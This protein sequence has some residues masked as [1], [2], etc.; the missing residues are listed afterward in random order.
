MLFRFADHVVDTDRRELSRGGA[1]VHVEPQVFD[2]LVHLIEERERVVGRDELFDV[3]WR[4]RIVSDATLD[5][6]I[7]AARRAVGDTGSRQELIRTVP[8][9]GYRFVGRLEPTEAPAAEGGDTRPAGPGQQHVTFCR[10]GDGTRIA[11]ASVGA[12][13]ALVKTA[14][15]L[16]HLEFDWESPVWAPL[17]Q[18]LSERH[19]LVRYDSRG[20]GLSDRELGEGLSFEDLVADLE[21]VVD[22]AGLRTFSLFGMSQGGAV[23]IAYAARH[24]ERVRALVLLGAYA[25]GRNRRGAPDE[26]ENAAALLTLMRAGWGDER[27]AFMQAFSSIYLPNGTPEQVR[28]FCELQRN[29]TSPEN[30]IR[31]RNACDEIDV[32][33]LLPLVRVPT[34]VLHGRRDTVVPY[35]QGRLVATSIP[36]ARFVS[37]DSEN[38]IILKGEPAWDRLMEELQGFLGGG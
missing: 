6:R 32:S 1:P 30:A 28:W 10:A 27:S 33:E 26:A 16:T 37:L 3:V 9:R 22:A 11:M 13:D 24:P 18:G 19:R 12:G 15:W 20:N 35:E 14:T 4:G 21:A 31:I 23:A 5:S 17:L 38:H 2:L 7:N 25:Q 36:G 29:T 34:L 8:R